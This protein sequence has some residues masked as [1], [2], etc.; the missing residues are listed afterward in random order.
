MG[1][2][3]QN[4]EVR[5][6]PGGTAVG[7]LRVVTNRRYK[8]KDGD[9]QEEAEFHIVEVWAKQAENCKE[10][11]EKGRLIY[12]EGRLKTDS[13]EDKESGQKRYKTKIVAHQVT[14]LP[15]GNGKKQEVKSEKPDADPQTEI[16]F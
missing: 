8:N 9:W 12:L 15:S 10:Y 13:W 4:P 11:L 6:T 7:D 3:A 2:L 1:R 16:P 14:F 5:Y